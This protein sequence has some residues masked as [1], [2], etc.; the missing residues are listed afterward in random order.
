MR[1]GHL[2]IDRAVWSIPRGHGHR[3]S[4]GEEMGRAEADWQLIIYGGAMHGFT[5]E[6]A[7]GKQVGVAYHRPSDE[8]SSMAIQSFLGEAFKTSGGRSDKERASRGYL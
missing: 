1:H 3:A 5:H 4:G 8:R 2:W 7:T 6:T